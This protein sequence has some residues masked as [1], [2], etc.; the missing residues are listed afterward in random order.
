MKGLGYVIWLIALVGL[1]AACQAAPELRVEDP[2][3]VPVGGSV[4]IPITL[5][6]AEA[7]LSGYNLTVTLS[8][9]A[10]VEVSAVSFPAWAPLHRG[11]AVPAGTTWIE[12]V[13][14]GDRAE[15]NGTSVALGTITLR[16]IRDGPA[17]LVIAP[18]RVQDDTGTSYQIS[19]VKTALSIGSASGSQPG[20]SGHS[21][22]SGSSSVPAAAVTTPQPTVTEEST[23]TVTTSEVP[24]TVT[25]TPEETTPAQGASPFLVVLIIAA[26]IFGFIMREK[27][28]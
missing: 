11:G 18:V 22:S 26:L 21:G 2:G 12:A 10:C 3:R 8:D 5:E 23:Q 4:E 13:D 25:G 16:G 27:K 1:V 19:E 15:G 7:G 28:E 17:D 20:S 6:G 9:P 24:A 14:L